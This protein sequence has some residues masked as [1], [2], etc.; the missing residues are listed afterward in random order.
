MNQA[1]YPPVKSIVV[2]MV[3]ILRLYFVSSSVFIRLLSTF[4]SGIPI[5]LSIA[6]FMVFK[7]LGG[8]VASCY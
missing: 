2:K 1:R 6:A 8:A 3:S 4:F 5:F 7:S